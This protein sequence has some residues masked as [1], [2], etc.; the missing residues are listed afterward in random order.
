MKTQKNYFLPLVVL[1]SFFLI[2][3]TTWCQDKAEDNAEYVEVQMKDGNRIRGKRL[4]ITNDGIVIETE[5]AG[6]LNLKYKDI[7]KIRPIKGSLLN[8]RYW[9]ENRTYMRGLVAPTGYGLREGEG[10][11][12]NYM[13]FL[14]QFNY[15]ITDH[16]SIG[17][18]TELVSLLSGGNDFGGPSYAVIPK[19]SLVASENAINVGVA[20]V[21]AGVAFTGNTVDF[22]GLYGVV[23]LGPPDR[24]FNFGLGFGVTESTIG[25]NPL[26]TIGGLYRLGNGVAITME[27]WILAQEAAS[28]FSLGVR[29]FGSRVSWDIT[30]VGGIVDG[31]FGGSPLPLVGLNVPIGDW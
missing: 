25:P 3:E 22:G 12:Q 19:L 17:I 8:A 15:G 31:F 26:V 1:F 30:F 2:S 11:Y 18:S 16:F 14:H 13:I 28:F 9:K 20:G 10:Y 4:A 21:V 7:D 24:F 6:K 29:L 27:N 5:I 23:T